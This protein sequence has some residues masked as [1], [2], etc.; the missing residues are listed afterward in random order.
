MQSFMHRGLRLGTL[1][2]TVCPEELTFKLKGT[3]MLTVS[4]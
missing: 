1:S 4:K 2:T 3:W